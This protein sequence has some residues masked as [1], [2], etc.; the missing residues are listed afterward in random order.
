M[1]LDIKE[2]LKNHEPF[3][4]LPE[5]QIE[6]I[7]QNSSLDYIPK[8]E[9]LIK[10]G[11][12]PSYLY[13]ILK[14]GFALKK[15]G[16][17]VE[18]LEKGDFIGDTSLI[19]NQE[20]QFTVQ[21]V[22]D[23]ILLLIPADIFKDIINKHP[24]F[25]E[26]FTK[27][28]INKLAEG[29]KKIQGSIDDSSLLPIKDFPLKEAFFCKKDEDIVEVA[30]KMSNKN[31]SFCLVGNP[32]DLQGIITDKDLKDRVIA[33]GKDPKTITAEDIKTFPV[34]TI[35]SD[36][37][38]FEAILKMINKNIKR[39]PVV[40]DGKVIGVIQ[41]RDIFIF[42]S[43]NI[44]YFIKQI[45]V[46]KDIKVLREIY[47]NVQ[48]SIKNLFKTGKDIEILQ[49][50][51]AELNDRFMQKAI[52]LTLEEFQTETEFSFIVL[53]SEGRKEQTLNTDIDNG[54]IYTDE[55]KQEI[56]LKIGKSIIDKL[57]KIGFPECPG[58]VMASNPMWV[59]SVNNWKTTI[60]NWIL[61]PDSSSIMYLSIFMDLRTIYGKEDF[62]EILKKHIFDMVE[63]NKNFL[64]V[65]ALKTL[66]FEPP[67]GFFRN[68]IV[69][70][71]GEHK[72]EL[73]IKKGGIFPIVQGIRV[74]A[75]ENKVE[76]TGT[77]DRIRQL[78][79]KIGVNLA[80]ELI[81]SFKFLQ[82]LRLK[83]QLEKLSEGKKPDNYINPEKLSK[84]E[85]DLLKD[86]FKVV[87]KFQEIIGVHYRIRV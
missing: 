51:T 71:T 81:E 48:E 54:I 40:E 3:S 19:F 2:F 30:R 26:F 85:K 79:N 31:L 1:S 34:E 8:D 60:D 5:S 4:L 49:K 68:F 9:I 67:I 36:K 18:F 76:E 42:Q 43:K 27:T 29:Y 12:F 16:N 55:S 70:K 41:D 56:I 61:R 73:D 37:F 17:I 80:D 65:M 10:S 39:L 24:E 22:E 38:L 53:G 23:S 46:E 33:K 77:I 58:K 83:F 44:L 13:M 72:N 69:E 78:R 84:F 66:E 75:L 63:N 11:Q 50:Y 7:V 25:K 15:D 35:E 87:K 45:Q 28:T 14:G 74:L 57:L 52:Q 59:K 6:Y 64:V 21:A 62:S 82:T 32:A 86:A 20:N 47:I